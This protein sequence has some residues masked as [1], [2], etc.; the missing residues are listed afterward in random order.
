MLASKFQ[1]AQFYMIETPSQKTRWKCR[2]L[3]GYT[4]AFIDDSMVVEF[5]LKSDLG[6]EEIGSIMKNI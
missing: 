4:G 1:N 6:E 5:T 3:E 2:L